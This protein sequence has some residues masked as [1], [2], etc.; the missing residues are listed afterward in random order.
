MGFSKKDA[1]DLERMAK[2][3]EKIANNPKY[4]PEARASARARADQV[5]AALEDLKDD[6]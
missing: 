3:D 6:E 2:I 1:A 4:T 5:N